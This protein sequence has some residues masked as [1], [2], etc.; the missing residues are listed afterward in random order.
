MLHAGDGS[1]D[2]SMIELAGLG[3][4]MGNA[5]RDVMLAADVVV[6]TNDED[7]T[8][9]KADGSFVCF[10]SNC[11]AVSNHIEICCNGSTNRSRRG[12]LEIRATGTG[13]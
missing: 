5:A 4:A 8:V 12:N 2:L 1:N 9:A 13:R 10:Y 11:T 3:V 7:G 6:G